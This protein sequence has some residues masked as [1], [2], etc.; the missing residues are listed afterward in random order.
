MGS[1]RSPEDNIFLDIKVSP[2]ASKTEIAGMQGRRLRIRIAAA[3]QDGKANN[4]LIAFMVKLLGCA[5]QDVSI[6][7]GEKSHLKTLRLPSS[8]RAALAR[9]TSPE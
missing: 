8:C 7:S 5:K 2:G 6:S 3:P 4:A 1:I 9:M